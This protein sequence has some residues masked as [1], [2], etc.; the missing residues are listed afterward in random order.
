MKAVVHERYGPPE[1][2][3]IRDVARPTPGPD[4]V[5]V[6]VKAAA[7]GLAT[8]E[9]RVHDAVG[10]QRRCVDDQCVGRG[11]QRGDGAAGAHAR[12]RPAPSATASAP[13]CAR[14]SKPPR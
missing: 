4:E 8:D 12:A 5:L 7:V 11:T 1:S 13:S 2:L 14:T 6:R 10:V 3:Q 9:Y